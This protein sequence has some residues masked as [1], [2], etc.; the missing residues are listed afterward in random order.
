MADRPF[1]LVFA[2]LLV[3]N[4]SLGRECP[5]GTENALELLVL[6]NYEA[7]NTTSF[8]LGQALER[9]GFDSHAWCT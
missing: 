4:S 9:A 6:L 8:S 2:E 5:A 1:F 7:H 3:A